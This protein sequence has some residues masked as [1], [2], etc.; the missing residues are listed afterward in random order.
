MDEEQMHSQLVL[1]AHKLAV[2]FI[3]LYGDIHPV[4]YHTS[5]TDKL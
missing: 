5:H 2:K 4:L 3:H 1:T